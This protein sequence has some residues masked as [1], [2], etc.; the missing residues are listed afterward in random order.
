MCS[1]PDAQ[2]VELLMNCGST[3]DDNVFLEVETIQLTSLILVLIVIL[4]LMPMIIL[5][6]CDTDYFSLT[7]S[8]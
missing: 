8:D 3:P 7:P 4:I 5:I 1:V 6:V 2:I